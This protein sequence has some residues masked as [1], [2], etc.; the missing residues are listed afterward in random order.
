MVNVDCTLVCEHPRI[1]PRAEEMAAVLAAV[2]E[3]EGDAV[4]IK[5]TRG[6]GMGPE[7]RSECITAMAVALMERS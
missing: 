7:G 6:E 4:S 1:A 2:L 3:I 5:A